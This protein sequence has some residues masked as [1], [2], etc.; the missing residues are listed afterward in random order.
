MNDIRNIL[1]AHSRKDF[2]DLLKRIEEAGESLAP[3][4][5]GYHEIA[6]NHC[7]VCG[8]DLST[9]GSDNELLSQCCDAEHRNNIA[10]WEYPLTSSR[11]DDDE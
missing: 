6:F 2:E 11:E 1:G 7:Q 9:Q 5:P 3:R 8:A 4:A 10:H